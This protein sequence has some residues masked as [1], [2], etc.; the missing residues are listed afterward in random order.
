[1]KK[2]LLICLLV[3]SGCTPRSF[4]EVELSFP[5]PSPQLVTLTFN[6]QTY[7]YAYTIIEDLSRLSLF[8]NHT[9]KLS[10]K[11]LIDRH[12]CQILVNG[13]FYDESD[14]PLGWLVS[15]GEILSRPIKSALFNGFLS[16][17]TS[18][19]EISSV[20]PATP[21][22]FG[23]QSGPLLILDSKPLSLKI[24]QDEPRRRVIAAMTDKNQLLFIT[25]T[26]AFL[27]DT[28]VLVQTISQDINQPIIAAINLD[29]GSASA[30][31]TP[32]ISFQEYSYI[33]SFFCYTKL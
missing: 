25:L 15:D 3:L 32:K 16:L 5:S 28:P 2:I 17:S 29:G 14:R 18:K 10:S 26:S 19:V 30:F 1:M 27:T 12:H 4:S 8:S 9:E 13:N 11:E 23:L 33:G 21:V 7:S 6:Q 31:H 24:K 20:L 22:N